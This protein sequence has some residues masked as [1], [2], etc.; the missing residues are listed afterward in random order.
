MTYFEDL[1]PF[2]YHGRAP[3]GVLNVGGLDGKRPFPTGETSE[4]FRNKLGRLCLCRTGY[5]S[6]LTI[7][8]SA[9]ATTGPP[10]M[11]RSGFRR[12]TLCMSLQ[13]LFI[14][15]SLSMHIYRRKRLSK[16]S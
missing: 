3:A 5:F 8:N 11:A 2:T 1:T 6:A 16:P 10:A 12:Q 15:T 13:R 14:T 7:V 9:K 4:E